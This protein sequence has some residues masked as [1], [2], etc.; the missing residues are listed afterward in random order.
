MMQ[1]QAEGTVAPGEPAGIGQSNQPPC[2]VDCKDG[3]SV[4]SQGHAVDGTPVP[5]EWQA[6]PKC[7]PRWTVDKNCKWVKKSPC[8]RY[9]GP[10][11]VVPPLP[12]QSTASLV[13]GLASSPA[14][15]DSVLAPE[16]G[17]R[18][19]GQPV[20][21][22]PPKGPGTV[23]QPVKRK[24]GP[25][26]SA[27]KPEYHK[28]IT[29]AALKQVSPKLK[30]D[31]LDAI[32]LANVTADRN[33]LTGKPPFGD[34][35]LHADTNQIRQAVRLMTETFEESLDPV[36]PKEGRSGPITWTECERIKRRLF[37]LG[38]ML[39][40]LQDLYAHSNWVE[41]HGGNDPVTEVAGDA[42]PTDVAMWP[43]FSANG[44]SL[45]PGRLASV[46]ALQYPANIPP[47]IWTG[48]YEHPTDVTGSH[49]H[50]T[51]NKD[52]PDSERGKM[53]NRGPNPKNPGHGWSNH[54]LAKGAATR[55][56]AEVFR[57][58]LGRLP[59]SLLEAWEKCCID[60]SPNK[61]GK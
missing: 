36:D 2:K 7:A 43:V 37:Y 33:W 40:T 42:T 6:D 52:D 21:P 57:A 59:K 51:I 31:C 54:E 10:G 44:G 16:P 3:V 60:S 14:V 13:A 28:E 18:T 20:V 1:V 32:V 29:T 5:P 17:P 22:L 35:P 39:H 47:G 38:R 19:V 41:R 11:D 58:W 24:R 61:A 48:D 15:M 4:D 23:G 9:L 50:A 30:D 34:K 25:M 46:Q 26:T 53:E 45:V 12:G 27:F 55:H 8:K 56:T 49:G